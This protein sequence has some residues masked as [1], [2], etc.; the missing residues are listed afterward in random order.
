MKPGQQ[1]RRDMATPQQRKQSPAFASSASF[2]GSPV[3]QQQQQQQQ[4][5]ISSVQTSSTATSSST[6]LVSPSSGTV[7]ATSKSSTSQQHYPWTFRQINTPATLFPR[8]GF[9]SNPVLAKTNPIFIFGGLFRSKPRN[10]LWVLNPESCTMRLAQKTNEVVSPRVGHASDL[11]GSVLIVFGGD[12]RVDG[13]AEFDDNLYFLNTS[14]LKWSRALVAGGGPGGRYGHT[15]N[16][17][18]KRLFLF[19]GQRDSTYL[20]DLYFFDLS[21]SQ[22]GE[23]ARWQAIRPLADISPSV[24]ANH[25]TTV[26]G[27]KLYLFGGTNG[28][29]CFND[30]WSFDPADCQ[31]TQLDCVGFLPKPCERHS[32]AIV[33]DLMYVFGGRSADGREIGSLTTLRLSTNRW[34]TFQNMGPSPSPRAGHSMTVSGSKIFTIGGTSDGGAVPEDLGTLYILDT[35]RIKYPSERFDDSAHAADHVNQSSK[36]SRYQ[37]PQQ[38]N[39]QYYTNGT[40]FGNSKQSPVIYTNGTAISSRSRSPPELGEMALVQVRDLYDRS[41]NSNRDLPCSQ[42][43]E[44]CTTLTSAGQVLIADQPTWT[45]AK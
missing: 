5:Q 13:N 39:G 42:R 23:P 26:F 12:T 28:Q 10:D 3:I 8:S 19:G 29:E 18:G 25:T 41:S 2:S 6:S 20:N 1:H 7:A 9:S 38:V 36:G 27:G 17:I 44:I 32:A 31:W 43:K 4:Q 37:P 33:G 34:F 45:A 14:T 24:R 21:K 11:I 16:I 30:T 15:I 22:V 35:F 40:G